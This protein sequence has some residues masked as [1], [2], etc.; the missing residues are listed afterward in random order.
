MVGMMQVSEHRTVG[1]R[2]VGWC[3]VVTLFLLCCFPLVDTDFWW[4]LKTG[5]LIWQQKAV[6]QFDWFTYMDADRRWID[7]HWGFQLLIAGLY[8]VGGASFVILFKATIYAITA[9]IGWRTSG[10]RIPAWAKGLLWIL[11]VLLMSGRALERPDMLSMLFLATT[12]WILQRSAD[13][14]RLIWWL[15]PLQLVWVNCHALF[16]LG[17]VADWCFV[18]GCVWTT[19]RSRRQR[20]SNT[21]PAG[22]GEVTHSGPSL[23]N[24]LF[25]VLLATAV[26]FLNPYGAEGF[27]FPLVLFRK[28]SAD[29]ALYLP[30]G[31]FR[32]PLQ[33]LRENE[34]FSIYVWA[35]FALMLIAVVS[36]AAPLVRGK[37]SLFRLLLLTGFGWLGWTATRNQNLF[38]LVAV[39]VICGNLDDYVK[40]SEI[41]A[42]SAA[43]T[44][45][46]K[47]WPGAA[48]VAVYLIWMIAVVTEAWGLAKW[49]D[50]HRRFRLGERKGWFVTGAARAARTP[51][52]PKYAFVNHFG[53]AAVYTYYNA[54][55]GKVFTDPRLEVST[56][57][58]FQKAAT[59][60]ALMRSG[61]PRWM[62]L[63]R[64]PDGELPVIIL[65][66]RASQ[67][68]LIGI[69]QTMSHL[70]R[71]IY[72]DSAGALLIED[73]L[74]ERLGLA[75]ADLSPVFNP[76]D[77]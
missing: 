3:V 35:H 22:A 23:I 11:P 63:V 16:V 60:T 53:Q 47:R 38:A 8:A 12:L 59:V 15:V 5:E 75:A 73:S 7:L 52:L 27:F 40:A 57:E 68:E 14:P 17:L 72:A 58:T 45:H 44:V 28:F 18:V 74:A 41:S 33:L 42:D 6:P 50:H 19:G 32:P 25:A 65:D 56:L 64:S 54:P 1:S 21:L 51:G 9:A 2:L 66:S 37:L 43:K 48:V 10:F 31:E 26:C 36:F 67:R 30:I 61:D 70:W 49:N 76:P 39:V 20:V 29:R 55:D 71:P 77:Y 13:R 4:Q 46:T 62:Q 69:A 24:V 34:W